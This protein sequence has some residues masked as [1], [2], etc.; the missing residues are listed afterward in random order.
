MVSPKLTSTLPRPWLSSCS[1]PSTAPETASVFLASSAPMVPSGPPSGTICMP[2][3]PQPWRRDSSRAAQSVIVPGVV[4][5]IRLPFRSATVGTL[6][7]LRTVMAM[8]S[9]GPAMAA[10]P[11]S[12]APRAM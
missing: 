11:F 3:G 9:I 12:V 4:M 6:P 5:P 10:T 1:P 2:S 8:F 7:S